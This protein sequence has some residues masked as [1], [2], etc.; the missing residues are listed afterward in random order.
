MPKTKGLY[1]N[2]PKLLKRDTLD[3]LLLGY[4]MGYRNQ[5]LLKVLEVR[6]A[7]IQFMEDFNLAEDDYPLDTAITTFYNLYK[8][9]QEFR[10]FIK[11]SKNESD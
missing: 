2:L 1:L 5:N 7:C 6:A 11:K 4:V 10:K 8:E 3:K 9:H